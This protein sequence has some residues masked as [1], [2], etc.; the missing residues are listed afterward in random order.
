MVVNAMLFACAHVLLVEFIWGAAIPYYI[1][2]LGY[3]IAKLYEE[4]RSI[5][6]CIILHGLNNGLVFC[7]DLV[8]MNYFL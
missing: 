6:P 3:L 1:F 5:G 4:S 8:K 2:A 7:I